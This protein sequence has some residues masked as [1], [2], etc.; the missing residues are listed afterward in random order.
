MCKVVWKSSITKTK[1]GIVLQAGEEIVPKAF[2][3]QVPGINHDMKATR[4]NN[5][6]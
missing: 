6:M 4:P 1:A 3:H 2:S 5:L